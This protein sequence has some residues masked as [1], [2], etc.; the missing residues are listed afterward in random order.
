MIALAALCLA[1]CGALVAAEGK[2]WPRLR[3][4]AKVVASF[5][6]LALGIVA[7][8]TRLD[9]PS[10][11][12]AFGSSAFGSSTFA[13]WIVA[14]LALGVAGDIALLGKSNRA[15]LVG[16]GVFLLGHVAYIV[17][18]A[19]QLDPREWLAD[20]SVFAAI[21]IVIA[22]AVVVHLWPRLGSMRVPVIAYAAVIATMVVGAIALYRVN[23][24]HA[25]ER[26]RVFVGDAAFDSQPGPY[27]ILLAGA[28]LFFAS[29]LSVARDKF[30]GASVA[31]KL[32]GLPAYYAGQL[33]IAW[34]L[35]S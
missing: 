8:R 22:L 30:V 16:L 34:S 27:G 23:P 20:A 25:L 15:F 1:A 32:W 3:I 11:F 12:P 29:D 24:G 4:G 13:T 26:A 9:M 19:T 35:T 6:F 10:M 17:A 5:A 7:S 33:L 21:P 18:F 31:N 28:C 2:H 14:G